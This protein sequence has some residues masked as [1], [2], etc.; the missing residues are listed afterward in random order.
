ME[1]LLIVELTPCLGQ[2]S[3]LNIGVKSSQNVQSAESF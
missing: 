1:I 2:S 3:V